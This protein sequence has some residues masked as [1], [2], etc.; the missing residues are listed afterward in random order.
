M[1]IYNMGDIDKNGDVF[2]VKPIE[3][4]NSDLF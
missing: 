1:I 2:D 4:D 3:G